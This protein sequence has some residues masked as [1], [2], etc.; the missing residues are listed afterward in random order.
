MIGGGRRRS[1]SAKR[2]ESFSP[3]AHIDLTTTLSTPSLSP[4]GPPPPPPPPPP[5]TTTTT[6]TTRPPPSSRPSKPIVK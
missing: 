3:K 6:T 4:S 5:T 1:R 2:E